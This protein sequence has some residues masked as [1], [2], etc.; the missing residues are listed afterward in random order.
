MSQLAELLLRAATKVLE[1][2]TVLWE[3]ERAFLDNLTKQPSDARLPDNY[4]QP[5]HKARLEMEQ[6]ARFL[7]IIMEEI[8]ENEE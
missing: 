4:W 7:E 1:A 2:K 5:E 8:H 6:A 3:R